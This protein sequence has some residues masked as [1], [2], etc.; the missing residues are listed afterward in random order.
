MC[1]F[2]I[3][4]SDETRSQSHV[5]E[6]MLSAI[7][8]RGPDARGIFE[9]EKFF[10]GH[11]RLSILDE[12]DAANQPMWSSCGRYLIVFNGEIYNHIALRALMPSDKTFRSGSSDTETLIEAISELGLNETLQ[13]VNGIFAFALYDNNSNTITLVRDHFGVKPLYFYSKNGRFFAAS[14]LRAFYVIPD[15]E[16]ILDRDWLMCHLAFRGVPAP[17]TLIKGVQKIESRSS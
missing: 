15:F 3:G 12:S 2:V 11:V 17:N 16:P 14:E 9:S 7:D 4:I 13:L 10:F 1:G 8:H 5:Y 6:G